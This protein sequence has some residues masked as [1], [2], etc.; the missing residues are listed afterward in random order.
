V[1]KITYSFFNHLTC[2][3]AYLLRGNSFFFLFF[4]FVAFQFRVIGRPVIT[5]QI[6]KVDLGGEIR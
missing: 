6:V 2:P 3:A 4:V 5:K 1:I